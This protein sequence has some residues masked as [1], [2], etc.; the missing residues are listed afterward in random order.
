MYE[1]KVKNMTCPSCAKSMKK[2]LLTLDP[3]VDVEV[4][5]PTQTVRVMS[6]KSQSEISSLIEEAGYPVIEGRKVN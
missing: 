5:L 2:A 1:F 3:T 4:N 6:D